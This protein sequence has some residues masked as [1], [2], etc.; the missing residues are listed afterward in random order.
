MCVL[1]K[2]LSFCTY[3]SILLI[4]FRSS[5]MFNAFIWHI[6]SSLVLLYTPKNHKQRT[7]WI[8]CQSM[9]L[10]P[11]YWSFVLSPFGVLRSTQNNKSKNTRHKDNGCDTGITLNFYIK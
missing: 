9:A 1:K 11:V 2:E 4:W 10:K 6:V 5:L 3:L 8:C 7:V